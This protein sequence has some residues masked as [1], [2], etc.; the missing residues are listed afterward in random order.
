M[1]PDKEQTIKRYLIALA[2]LALIEAILGL[3]LMYSG[4]AYKKFDR[5]RAMEMFE[6]IK[7][8]NTDYYER[9]TDS[10]DTSYMRAFKKQYTT[11][12]NETLVFSG[13]LLMS[14]AVTVMLPLALMWMS[15]REEEEI[16]LPE[17]EEAATEEETTA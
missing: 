13:I 11:R 1:D 8:T 10:N 12:G 6:L 9:L 4:I 17:K 3:T 5:E 7:G 14:F 2:V 15:M 16:K